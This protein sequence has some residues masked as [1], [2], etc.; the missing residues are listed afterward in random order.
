MTETK[1]IPFSEL[2]VSMEIKDEKNIKKHSLFLN[3]TIVVKIVQKQG[4]E[5]LFHMVL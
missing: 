2:K 5:D 3:V 1:Y 4:L